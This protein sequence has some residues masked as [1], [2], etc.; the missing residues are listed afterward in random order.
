MHALDLAA[1]GKYSPVDNGQDALIFIL[2]FAAIAA[3]SYCL[4]RGRRR[5]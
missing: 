4:L 1:S 5:K 3:V 2:V